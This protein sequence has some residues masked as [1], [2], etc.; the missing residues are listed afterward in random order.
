MQYTSRLEQ[1]VP[2]RIRMNDATAGIDQKHPSADAVERVGK[3][4]SLRCLEIDQVADEQRAA[5]VRHEQA[6]APARFIIEQ[7][8]ALVAEHSEKRNT[9]HRLVE[10]RRREIGKLLWPHP[11][12]I[13]SCLLELVVWNDIGRANRLPK[14]G[15]KL[16]CGAWIELDVLLEI[17]LPVGRIKVAVVVVAVTTLGDGILPGKRR[18]QTADKPLGSAQHVRPQRRIER[19]IVDVAGQRT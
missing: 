3:R 5:E 2:R 17:E 19:G 9:R 6:D 7:P 18:G 4:G 13:E 1:R 14:F 16:T 8:V 10:H 15:K 11:L 12:L